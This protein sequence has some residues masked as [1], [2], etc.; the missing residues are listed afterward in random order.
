MSETPQSTVLFGRLVYGGWERY[1]VGTALVQIQAQSMHNP[2]LAGV[3][4]VPLM[5]FPV[6]AARNKAVQLARQCGADVLFLLDNDMIPHEGFFSFAVDF[7]LNHDGPAVIA[8]PYCAG[9]EMGFA[10]MSWEGE[11]SILPVEAGKRHGV[12]RVSAAGFGFAAFRM[13][14]F[15]KIEP[16][17][18]SFEWSDAEQT[19]LA[20]GEDIYFCAKGARAGVPVYVAWDFWSGH[21]K[22]VTVGRPSHG[23]AHG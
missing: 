18:F 7:L 4:F 1:E 2:R 6:S 11:M 3:Y 13:D 23:N 17:H 9:Q 15:D 22:E 12:Q 8:S 14:A 10:V 19:V 16:P 21:V 20:A 5:F